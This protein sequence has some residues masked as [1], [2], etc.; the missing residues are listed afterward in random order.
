MLDSKISAMLAYK[1]TE[2]D[3]RGVS[4]NSSSALDCADAVRPYGL[5]LPLR[6]AGPI[7]KRFHIGDTPMD[8]Q[9]CLSGSAVFMIWIAEICA[10]KR[11]LLVHCV[12]PCI[13]SG[14][15]QGNR[16]PPPN[17][18]FAQ[19]LSVTVCH[20][21]SGY[22]HRRTVPL[23]YGLPPYLQAALAAGAVP[24][25]V[26]TG[27]FSRNQLEA[28]APGESVVVLDSLADVPLV[29]QTLGLK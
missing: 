18:T 19:S 6:A 1:S 26:A 10:N 21:L 27:I 4:A 9:V 24:I 29:L 2:C 7:G 25:A 14:T 3:I 22:L 5:W 11:S 12:E 17:G 8:V 28:V 20:S 15:T 13:P 16:L 23:A